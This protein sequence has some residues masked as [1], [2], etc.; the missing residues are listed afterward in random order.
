MSLR[1]GLSLALGS[2]PPT[3]SLHAPLQHLTEDVMIERHDQL[4]MTEASWTKKAGADVMAEARA[5]HGCSRI[6]QI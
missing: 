5:R 3:Q 6:S 2:T 4:V 1:N